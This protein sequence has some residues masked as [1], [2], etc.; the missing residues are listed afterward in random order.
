MKEQEKDKVISPLAR[1]TSYFLIYLTG[2]Y[3]LNSAMAGG[4]TSDNTKTQVYNSGNVPIVNIAAPNNAGISHNTYQDFN[5]GTQGAV[6]NNATQAI[7]SQLAGQINANVNLQGKAAELIINEVTGSNRSELLGQ[8]EVAGQKA[9]VMIANPNGITCDGCGFI[10]TSGAILTTG[11]PQFD[12]QGALEALKVTKGQI[13]IGGKGLNGQSTDYIDIISRATELNGKIQANN[14]SL[15]QGAN[16]ISFKDGT[17]KTIAGEGATPQLAVDTK[18]LG[19]M[20][21][22]KIRLIATENGVGVNLK[23]I[24]STQGDITLSSNGKMELGNIKSKTDLSAG[25]KEINIR[26]NSPVQAELNIILAGDKIA[27]K[28]SV[29]AGQDMRVLGNTI[30][31]IGS[32]VLL[33]AN[34]NMW[35]QK[36]VAGNKNK[37]VLNTGT[38][39]TNQGDIVIRSEDIVNGFDDLEY[40][41]NTTRFKLKQGMFGPEFTEEGKYGP[42]GYPQKLEHTEI[43]ITKKPQSAIIESGKSAYLYGD[44]I[45]NKH[46]NII[47]SNDLILT[48]KN[49]ENKAFSSGS[50]QLFADYGFMANEVF[51]WTPT[52]STETNLQAKHNLVLD[53]KNIDVGV[54]NPKEFN[55]FKKPFG[56][57]F[58]K[59]KTFFDKTPLNINAKSINIVGDSVSINTTNLEA[60]KNINIIS[61]DKS[62]IDLSDF[63]AIDDISIVSGNNISLLRSKLSS[64]NI[65][66]NSFNGNIVSTDGLSYDD[67]TFYTNGI[68][69]LNKLEA[70][71]DLTLSSNNGNIFIRNN[72]FSPMSSNVSM[73]ALK[74]IDIESTYDLIPHRSIIKDPSGKSNWYEISFKNLIP[75]TKLNSSNS[76]LMTSG[77]NLSLTSVVLNAKKDINFNAKNDFKATSREFINRDSNL[78]SSQK[79]VSPHLFD[80]II[81]SDDPQLQTQIHAGENLLINASNDIKSEGAKFSA[82]NSISLLAGNSM[83]LLAAI[84]PVRNPWTTT[85]GLY[86]ETVPLESDDFKRYF[87]DFI[88]TDVPATTNVDAGKDVIISSGNEITTEGSKISANQNINIYS[89][90]DIKFNAS[91]N[92]FYDF[93]NR[94]EKITR[95]VTELNSGGSLNIISDGSILFQASKLFAKGLGAIW[96]DPIRLSNYSG[97]IIEVESE[98]QNIKSEIGSITKEKSLVE[99]ELSLEKAEEKSWSDYFTAGGTNYDAFGG[100]KEY[101]ESWFAEVEDPLLDEIRQKIKTKQN[102]LTE[103]ESRLAQANS[104]LNNHMNKLIIAKEEAKNKGE[105]ET[106]IQADID[107]H[108]RAEAMRIGTINIAA[109]GGYLYAAASDEI[110]SFETINEVK[111]GTNNKVSEFIASGDIN[112]LSRDD[113]TYEAS[114]IEAGQNITLTSTHGFTNFKAVKDTEYERKFSKS[115]GFFIKTKDKGHSSET[116]VLPQ[117]KWNGNFVVDA[118]QG[119]TSD[120]KVKNR[121]SLQNAIDI[122]GSSSETVWFKD[123]NTRHDIKWNEVQDAYDSWDH[124]S[125][126]LSPVASAVI[127]IAVAAVTAGAGATLAAAGYAAGA[128]TTAGAS[129]ATASAASG[130]VTAGMASLASTAAVSLINNQGNVSKTLKEMGSSQTVKSTVTSMAIGGALAGFDKLMGVEKMANGTT[131]APLLSKGA[132]WTKVAQRVAGQSIISSGV[133]T[134]I[135]GGS[136]KDKFATA[137]LSNVGN[138]INAEGANIIGNNSAELGVPGKAVSHAAVSA[139]AAEIGGGDAKGAAAGALAVSL[140]ETVLIDTFSDPAKIEAGGKMIGGIA[141]AFATNSAEGV[142]SGANSGE[143][144]IV[145]NGLA[146]ALAMMEREVPGTIK[147]HEESRKILCT[148]APDACKMAA[149]TISF[150]AD[151]MPGISDIKSFAEAETRL[152][153][154]TATIGLVPVLGDI[155]SKSIKAANIAL[156][157]GNLEVAKKLIHQ[158]HDEISSTSL[159]KRSTFEAPSGNNYT[160]FQQPINWELPINTKG[161]IIKTNLQIALDGG[162]PFVV[163]N[164]KYSQINLHHSKQNGLGPLFELSSDTHKEFHSSNA[165]HPYL[166]K[167]HPDT[168][169]D[170]DL[171]NIDRDAYWVNRAETELKIRLNSNK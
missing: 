62:E 66:L 90:G 15:T 132:D 144:T 19:G 168:P 169:V 52:L 3:P 33:Q 139:L 7:N 150:G 60:T 16:Q 43:S 9:N 89:G 98:I 65:F 116:W 127:A 124:K 109:K 126:Q 103:V 32:Q 170:R 117:I 82:G 106:K 14:L 88:R 149:R 122:L 134:A 1:G 153:Y 48:G 105:S 115:N 125:Q 160:V 77:N 68:R 50:L 47:A 46:S 86:G 34:N 165:L 49:L 94:Q 20:Y 18:A 64:D 121:Q 6:L 45:K 118:A 56:L 166:P 147:A 138:Q 120:I 10:N 25:G 104:K 4:I 26:P 79:T 40:N 42:Y 27:N 5:T 137:L 129:A 142:N 75:I 76:I 30:S 145:Y 136:F 53:F 12:A 148:R 123:L 161:G 57:L 71:N 135:N 100:S 92:Y 55:D 96:K 63:K 91:R 151:F 155:A 21:A 130:A 13:T 8:L 11:K 54:D 146:H 102:K 112:I 23:D 81:K 41:Y 38:I 87:F 110:K 93:P 80:F 143:I 84:F 51:L 140:A 99:S 158:A 67:E 74:N 162:S 72:V 70:T 28:G 22:N 17:L 97:P 59:F 85:Q 167:A 73:Y 157:D 107:D 108:N 114:K 83:N 35:I 44:N 128:A 164:G 58:K 69:R 31:N 141:G 163:K 119:I 133:N 159:F 37:E 95:N 2:I 111:Y 36:N 171:F 61:E 156:K 152:D 78:S 154:L 24:T 101:F 113:S 39:R 131:N 29:T